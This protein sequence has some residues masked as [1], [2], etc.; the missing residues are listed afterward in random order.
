MRRRQAFTITELLVVM[1]LIVFIMYILAEAFSAASGAFRRLKAV[2]D[3]NG[4]LRTTT[5]LLRRY[6]SADHF[7]GKKRLSSPSFWYDGPPREG[8]FRIWQDADSIDEGTDLDTNHSFRAP[9]PDPLTGYGGVNARGTWSNHGLHFAVKLRGNTR[10]A[11]FRTTLTGGSPLLRMPQADTRFQEPSGTTLCSSWA[12]VAFFLR[13]SA[14]DSVAVPGPG[15]FD[16]TEDYSVP[17]GRSSLPLYT[18]Y[19]RQRLVIADNTLV[20]QAVPA[21]AYLNNGDYA[22]MSCYRDLINPKVLYFNNPSDLT[23]PGRR[24]GKQPNRPD[25]NRWAR[26]P[27]FTG[28]LASNSSPGGGALPGTPPN[29]YPI[30]AEEPPAAGGKFKGDDILLTNV[31]S[32][33]VRVL[34]PL[35]TWTAVYGVSPR[36]KSYD[37]VTLADPAVQQFNQNTAGPAPFRQ[38]RPPFVFDTWSQERDN[39]LDYSGWAARNTLP[40]IPLWMNP[41]TGEKIRL[42]A[43]Q[44]TIRIWDDNTRQTRQTSLVV[45]L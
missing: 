31:V 36:G 28:D 42:L 26:C 27:A 23:M 41:A 17:A 15:G 20:P 25:P 2:G 39:S 44:I 14:P 11:F 37:F 10:D 8:F 5:T 4:K 35:S 43:I 7:E 33:E 29:G 24:L 3:M 18:L 13:P 45:D 6:L 21:N 30:L 38:N 12:E 9:G 34:L 22:E 40:S 19:M 32:F 16:Q 1:A